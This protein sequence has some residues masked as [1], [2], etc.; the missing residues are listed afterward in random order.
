MP[1]L[2]VKAIPEVPV[3]MLLSVNGVSDLKPEAV[4]V[5]IEDL[6]EVCL[7]VTAFV[8]SSIQSS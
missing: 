3:A 2:T 4:D 5:I 7:V 1:P 8:K 6:R